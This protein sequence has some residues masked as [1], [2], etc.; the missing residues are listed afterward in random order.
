MKDSLTKKYTIKLGEKEIVLSFSNL[1]EQANC[2]IL[3]QAGD[4][5]VL[6]TVVMSDADKDMGYFPL[7]VEY[8][9]NYYAAGKIGGGR[10]RKREGRPSDDSILKARLIDRALR[11]LFNKNIRK[12]IQIVNSVLSYDANNSPEILALV[13]SATALAVSDIPFDAHLG[14]VRVAKIGDEMIVSPSMEEQERSS[15]VAVIAGYE[16]S[17][18]MIEVNAKEAQDEE[19]AELIAFGSKNIGIIVDAQK[20]IC[21]KIGKTKKDIEIKEADEKLKEYVRGIAYEKLQSTIFTQ[22]KKQHDNN[23]KIVTEEVRENLKEKYEDTEPDKIKYGCSF[24]EELID[25]IIHKA[26]LNENKR[27]DGRKFDEVRDLSGYSSLLP[28]AHGSGVFM[29]G[30]THILSSTTLAI[31]GNEEMH[32]D[33]TGDSEKRFMHHYNFPPYSVGEAGFFRGPGRREVGH[34]ALAERALAPLIPEKE[35]FPYVIRLVSEVLSSNGSSSMGSVCASS[36]AL[37]DAGV[38]VKTHVAGIAMGLIMGDND[39]FKILTDIQGPEDHY[40]DMDLKVA[41]TKNG[42]TAMQMDVKIKGVSLD[43][44]KQSFAQAQKARLQIIQTLE[45]IISEPRKELSQYAPK[46]ESL[47]INPDKIG[48]VIGSG[49][50]VIKEIQEET[51]TEINIQDDGFVSVGGIDR[52]K[53][54]KAIAKIKSLTHEI[55][56][57]DQYRAKVVKIADFGA[58]V[59]ITQDQDALVHI[60]ELKGDFVKNIHDEV[61]LDEVLTIRILKVEDNGKISATLKNIDKNKEVLNLA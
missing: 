35:D 41:G 43:I 1:A 14:A 52:E 61:S 59:K 56:A 37:F 46:I 38:P 40:G 47:M 49:G 51:G 25:E 17:I 36:V 19:V 60:S 42:V 54:Q 28:R 58:F 50:S 44:L 2:S 20:E 48:A 15:I 6:T 29:R 53:I 34:G 30:L 33:M 12:E 32:D 21:N 27:V 57:G 11:P 7:T 24:L 16:N 18:N 55:K 4:T 31:T 39:K 5:V 22:D 3:A 13:A 9:E 23:I 26:A 45:S 8:R 10:F